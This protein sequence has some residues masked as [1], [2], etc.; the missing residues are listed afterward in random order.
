VLVIG[1]GRPGTRQ[2]GS[3]IACTKS[4]EAVALFGCN[5]DTYDSAGKILRRAPYSHITREAVEKALNAFRGN[6]MQK[7]PM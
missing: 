1:V 5:T 4:Y 7:P 6:I 3:F 2:L